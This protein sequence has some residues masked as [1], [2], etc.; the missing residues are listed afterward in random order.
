MSWLAPLMLGAIV[1]FA[2]S[3]KQRKS[4]ERWRDIQIETMLFL[5]LSIVAFVLVMIALFLGQSRSALIGVIVTVFGVGVFAMPTARW[6]YIA[7]AGVFALIVLQA[8]VFFNLFPTSTDDDSPSTATTGVSTRDQRTVGQ[9][10]D[11]WESAFAIMSDYPLTGGGL[12]SFRYGFVRQQY[13]VRGFNMPYDATE[14]DHNHTQKP[15]PHTHNT[16]VQFM[17]DMGIPGLLVALGLHLTLAYML[18]MTWRKGQ[19]LTRIAVIAVGAGILSQLIFG[20]ADAIPLWDRF[21]FIFWLM[22]GLAVGLYVMQRDTM[23]EKAKIEA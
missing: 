21:S 10:F 22:L 18:F 4:H 17:A 11:I 19:Q 6:R 16:F 12:N 15:I 14:Y 7:I 23:A 3:L 5:A 2:V 20:M 8:G 9:R 13:P 1:Y